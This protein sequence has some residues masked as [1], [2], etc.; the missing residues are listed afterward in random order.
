MKR[1]ITTTL[2]KLVIDESI[3]AAQLSACKQWLKIHGVHYQ[4]LY[5]IA[6][7][8]PGM[9][10]AR[11]LKTVLNTQDGLLTTDRPFHNR[12]LQEGIISFYI[13]DALAI[14]RQ[15]LKGIRPSFLPVPNGS[16]EK[17]AA[18]CSLHSLIM[19]DTDKAQKKLRTKRRRIRNHFGGYDQLNQL[20]I[21]VATQSELIGVR[22]QVAGSSAKGIM[23][24]ESYIAES[25][26]DSD[27]DIGKAA[28]CHALVLT[29]QLMLHRLDVSVF[30]HPATI[31][32]PYSLDDVFFNR[33]KREF[34][35][36]KFIACSKGRHMEA[37]RQKLSALHSTKTNEII[38][39]RLANIK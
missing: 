34:P 5:F 2:E 29:L 36:V 1:K 13:D 16:D 39:S 21:A 26:N 27:Y 32:D 28:L 30:Y 14:T 18:M 35:S 33:L 11:I 10:D 38:A 37:L 22:L 8:H 31:P 19:P 17:Q 20:S 23:A 25:D 3:S 6:E 7:H 12:L 15:A 24:S 4:Q 9:P